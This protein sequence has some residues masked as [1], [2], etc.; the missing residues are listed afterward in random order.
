MEIMAVPHT[1]LMTQKHMIISTDD[2]LIRW[3]KVNPPYDS[4]DGKFDPVS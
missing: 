1:T 3:Y 2:G 4:P